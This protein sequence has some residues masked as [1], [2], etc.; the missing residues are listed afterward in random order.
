M[1]ERFRAY[2]VV[3]QEGRYVGGLAELPVDALPEGAVT[4]RVHYSSLNYKDALSASGNP[5]VT[6]RYPHTPGIDAAGMVE[7][8]SDPRFRAGDEVIVTS[9]DLG[10]N[11]PGGFAELIRVPGDWVVPLPAGLSLRE[12]MALGTAGFTAALALEAL[13]RQ[14]LQAGPLLVTGASGGVGSVATALL[15][16]LGHEVWAATGSPEAHEL[17]RTLGAGRTVARDELAEPSPRPMLKGL[18]GGAIDTVGGETLANVVKQLAPHASA[19]ACGVVGGAELKLTVYPFILRGVNLLGVDSQSC[20]MPRR[21]ELWR[22]LA[23]PWKLD[24][25]PLTTE[26]GLE[27]LGDYLARILKGQTRGRV[28]VR[29]GA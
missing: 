13:E 8:S 24:L 16:K 15:A 9:Y 25:E 12:A 17:L 5:G 4:V 14:G 22:K 18:Y 10:M 29:V 27:Q 11:T 7:A 3:Q 2:R 28:L 19:A 21:V 20:P 26:I 6:K 1:S 23:G